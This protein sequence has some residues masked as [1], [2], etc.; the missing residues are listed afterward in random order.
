[1]V[2][3]DSIYLMINARAE[4]LE[5]EVIVGW[6]NVFVFVIGQVAFGNGQRV[7]SFGHEGDYSLCPLCILTVLRDPFPVMR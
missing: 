6:I 5:I 4:Y 2:S 7:R 1:M 3:V